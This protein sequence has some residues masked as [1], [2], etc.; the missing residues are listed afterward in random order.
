[1]KEYIRLRCMGIPHDK[2][3]ELANL[4]KVLSQLTNFAIIVGG[5]LLLL[6]AYDWAMSREVEELEARIEREQRYN[7][8]VT[9]LVADI[10]ESK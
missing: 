4:D 3:Y 10:L 1:M 8:Q 6:L 7:E 2:A 9:K 5:L